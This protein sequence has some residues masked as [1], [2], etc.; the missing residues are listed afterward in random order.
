M[1]TYNESTLRLFN[2]LVVPDEATNHTQSANLI[3]ETVSR[4]YVLSPKINAKPSTLQDVENVIGLSVE[5]A[6][7]SFHKSWHKVAFAPSIQLLLEQLVHYI[8]TYGHEWQGIYDERFVYI[9]KERLDLPHITSDIKLVYINAITV[10]ELQD[11]IVEL[12][13]S[14]IAL[15]KKSV[16]DVLT[17]VKQSGINLSDVAEDVK[18]RE[19]KTALYDYY[20][21]SPSNPEEWLRF[22]IYKLTGETLVIKNKY[23]ISKI[24]QA[25][26]LQ[27][28]YLDALV[29]SAPKNLASIFLR[30]KPLFLAMKKVSRDKGFFNKLRK[31]ANYLHRP[32][33]VNYLNSVTEQISNFKLNMVQLD[34][35]LNNAATVWQKIKLSKA[36]QNRLHPSSSVA[37]QVRNGK[38]YVKDFAWYGDNSLTRE[39]L[40]TVLESLAKDLSK[41]VANRIVYIPEYIEYALPSSE[42]QFVGNFPVGTSVTVDY[43][44]IVGIHWFNSEGDAYYSRVDLDLSYLDMTGKKTGWDASWRNEEMLFSGDVTT[45][46]RPNGA[47]ESFYIKSHDSAG[48]FQVNFFNGRTVDNKI[49]AKIF[50]AKA[51]DF[52]HN[53][54]VNPSKILAQAQVSLDNRQTTLG[55]LDGQEFYF[56]GMSL[57]S[58]ISVRNSAHQGKLRRYLFD[59][60]VNTIKLSYLLRLAGAVVVGKEPVEYDDYIDLSPNNLDKTTLLDLFVNG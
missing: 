42:K 45:A 1:I 28:R 6:N 56:Y 17:I 16:E 25:D 36:L 51:G 5:K 4:G 23:L 9:P 12:L 54:V 22:A 19:V 11:K 13:T 31:D 47:Q 48:S 20:S 58:G 18:N 38:G 60:S 14:G 26:G 32:L 24:V 49:D 3:A 33:A 27:R 52:R 55:F 34:N 59:T 43:D 39:A 40:D 21:I 30:Y 57:G 46:P 29:E 50:V 2:S 41:K 53:Y 10:D 15:S 7:A 35:A 8:T 44:M 37:Y